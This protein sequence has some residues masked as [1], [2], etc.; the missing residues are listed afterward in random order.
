M[1]AGEPGMGMKKRSGKLRVG[2]VGTGYLGTFHA[3]KYAAMEGVELAAV[4]DTDRRK[5]SDIARKLSAKA[6]GRPEEIH[7]LVDAVSIAVPTLA[8]YEVT[9]GFL[10]RGV[11]VLI[12]KPMTETLPEATQLIRLAQKKGCILQ[13]GHLERFNP[14]WDAAHPAL[15]SPMFIEAH[16]LGPFQD[17]GT[18]VDVVLDLMIHDIDIVLKYVK[19]PVRKVY[20]AGVPVL[21]A[22]TDIANVRMHFENG[23]VA[24]LT[25]SRVSMKK[26]RKIRFFQQ[27][28]YV[29]VDYDARKTQIIRRIPRG[30]NR[31]PE[32]TGEEKIAPKSDSLQAELTSFIHCVKTRTPPEVDGREGRRALRV[33]IRILRRMRPS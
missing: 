19:S 11:D 20:A 23:A 8:H 10:Q 9:R 18:D 3:Q 1:E 2:V 30:K 13:V 7:D 33:A 21:S 27:D 14:V 6:Y 29:S 26:T 28:L 24:N 15:D 31:T 17:R 5:A 32:I 22:N 12:E 16:R 25:A 4:V